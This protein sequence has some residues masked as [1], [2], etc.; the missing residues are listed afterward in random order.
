MCRLYILTIL[1]VGFCLLNHQLLAQK[2]KEDNKK[3]SRQAKK[4]MRE[5]YYDIEKYE[6]MKNKMEEAQKQSDSIKNKLTEIQQEADKT[7]QDVAKL[8]EE[9]EKNQ[10]LIDELKE[11]TKSAPTNSIPDTGVFYSVQIG[12]YN[13]RDISHL[14]KENEAELSVEQT[15]KGMKKY[16]IGGYTT[17]EEAAKSRLQIRKL[18]FKDAWIVAH[19]DGQRIDMTLI[20]DTPISEEELQELNKIK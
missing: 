8:K 6:A 14:I 4:E 2:N 1:I 11:Q 20:R 16:L 19:K 17:Y 9:Q 13:R 5:I 12:A 15:D 7:E 3:P 10:Q 18:G